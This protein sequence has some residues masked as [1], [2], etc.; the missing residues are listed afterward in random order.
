MKSRIAEV[1]IGKLLKN[2][3]ISFFNTALSLGEI[4]KELFKKST[5]ISNNFYYIEMIFDKF[6]LIYNN[7]FM[8][9]IDV[10]IRQYLVNEKTLDAKTAWTYNGSNGY[11]GMFIK[12][13]Y[14]EF[15][16]QKENVVTSTTIV[17]TLNMVKLICQTSKSSV[18]KMI[19]SSLQILNQSYTHN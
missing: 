19:L 17:N 8:Y 13:K 11:Y 2:I 1:T 3:N 9:N 18:F 7:M 14:D 5:M 12:V 16:D 6:D 15:G 10:I 4:G